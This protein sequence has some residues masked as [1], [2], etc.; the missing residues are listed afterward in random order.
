MKLAT[1]E[2][3]T[4][5]EEI[6]GADFISGAKVLG[7]KSVIKKN[8]FAVG[9]LVIFIRPD[10][11]I[12]R[13]EWNSFLWPKD[14]KSPNG[15]PIKIKACRFRG[16]CS[17]GL[18]VDLSILSKKVADLKEGDDVT[19]ILEI[20]KYVK[21]I[22]VGMSGDIVGDFPAFLK[23][24]DELNLESYPSVISHFIGKPC[25][26]TVKM[27]GTSCTAYNKNGK[28]GVCS[29]SKELKEG[30]NVYWVSARKYNLEEAL[31]GGDLALQYE[32]V[33]PGIN[34][35][36]MN[37]KEIEVRAFNLWDCENLCYCSF[38]LFKN[39]CSVSKIPIA[40]VVW[41]G[42][43]N[44]NLEYLKQLSNR[45][46]YSE[47]LPAEGIVF[48]TIE[49]SYCEILNG[50]GSVKILNENFLIKYGE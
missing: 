24:T 2:K 3:I 32:V 41:C 17:Q 30:N 46:D 11:I 23:R 40:D 14:D 44:G 5:I 4:S 21:E 39:F 31:K 27:D 50:R 20:T 47:G 35:N 22:P 9:D 45:Q 13:E 28:F 26:A 48:R 18:I 25:I 6:K 7:F 12:K 15:A 36:K 16:F 19:E 38:T 42:V 1:I 34:G 43:F 10:S 29:R 8:Q 49:E 37:L 33:G